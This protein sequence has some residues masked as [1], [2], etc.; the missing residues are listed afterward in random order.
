[1][2]NNMHVNGESQKRTLQAQIDYKKGIFISFRFINGTRKFSV[3][4]VIIYYL[5]HIPWKFSKITA[6]SIYRP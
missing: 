2:L 1:M 6:S 5:Y 4:P 3:L